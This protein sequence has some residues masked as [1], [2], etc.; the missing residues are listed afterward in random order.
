MDNNIREFVGK[1]VE[2]TIVHRGIYHIYYGVLTDINKD[3]ICLL[4]DDGKDKWIR[5]PK[6]FNDNIKEVE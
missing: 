1:Q 2:V 4:R 5:R 6:R 3:D